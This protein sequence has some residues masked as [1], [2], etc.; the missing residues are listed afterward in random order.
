[1]GEVKLGGM[2]IGGGEVGGAEGWRGCY[3]IYVASAKQERTDSETDLRLG[4]VTVAQ[5]GVLVRPRQD[6]S[7]SNIC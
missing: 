3:R 6:R 4:V 2:E 5:R 1:M 7:P